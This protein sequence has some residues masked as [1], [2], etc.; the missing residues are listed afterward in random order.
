MS[1]T[2]QPILQNLYMVTAT[3]EGAAVSV[4]FAKWEDINKNLY[5]GMTKQIRS[6]FDYFKD[7]KPKQIQDTVNWTIW[8]IP[9]EP[10]RGGWPVYL[11]GVVRFYDTGT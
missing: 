9:A 8:G 11:E 2:P 4:R 3:Y 5:D 10:K 6:R 1:K 7:M